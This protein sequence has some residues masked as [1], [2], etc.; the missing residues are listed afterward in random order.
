[1]LFQQIPNEQIGFIEDKNKE[2][3]LPLLKNQNLTPLATREL[4]DLAQNGFNYWAVIKLKNTS[5]YDRTWWL[6]VP[7][8]YVNTWINRAGG[9]IETSYTGNLLTQKEKSV[10]GLFR[11]FNY[12]PIQLQE[13]LDHTYNEHFDIGAV[14]QL[15]YVDQGASRGLQEAPSELLRRYAF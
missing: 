3:S 2:L 5:K 13:E 7:G 9:P 10:K 1:M 11:N 6:D 8:N 4:L 14:I 15:K 12:V